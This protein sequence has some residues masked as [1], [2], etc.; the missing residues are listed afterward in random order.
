[1]HDSL[2]VHVL[3]GKCHLVDVFDDTFLLKVDFVFHGL[4]NDKFQ[5]A[6]FC[7]LDGNEELVQLA[8]DKPAQILD[9]VYLI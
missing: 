8:I 7:P 6:F 9:D 1:M 2:L 4:L 5:I 3:Q